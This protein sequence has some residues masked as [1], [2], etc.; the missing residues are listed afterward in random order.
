[1]MEHLDSKDLSRLAQQAVRGADPAPRDKERM[2]PF[3]SGCL[4][5]R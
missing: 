1:M 4:A 5:R 2:V 3:C